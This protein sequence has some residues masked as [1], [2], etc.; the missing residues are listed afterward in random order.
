MLTLGSFVGPPITVI[1]TIAHTTSV[2]FGLGVAALGDEGWHLALTDFLE[3]LLLWIILRLYG[4]CIIAEVEATLK[5]FHFLLLYGR[6]STDFIWIFI[7]NSTDT[8][9]AYGLAFG[10]L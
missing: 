6:Y 1:A 10:R 8:R 2:M 4:F 7:Q 3:L 5:I 9:E